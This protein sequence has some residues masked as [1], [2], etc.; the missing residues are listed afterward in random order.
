MDANF[1]RTHTVRRLMA[2]NISVF[3]RLDPSEC[4]LWVK[5]RLSLRFRT[6]GTFVG[7]I[8]VCPLKQGKAG[9]AHVSILSIW[10]HEYP[11]LGCGG[12]F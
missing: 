12:H 9:S 5:N 2:M 1:L 8:K 6:N 4:V 3:T 7:F 10:A 11:E